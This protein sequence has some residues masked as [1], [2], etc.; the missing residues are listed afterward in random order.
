[1]RAARV[2]RE[3]DMRKSN[4]SEDDANGGLG[5]RDEEGS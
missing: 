2:K 1:M 3:Q 4:A 5:R